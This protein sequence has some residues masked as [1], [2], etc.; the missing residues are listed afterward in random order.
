MDNAIPENPH[1]AVV[2]YLR[3]PAC[4]KIAPARIAPKDERPGQI[5]TPAGWT[6]VCCGNRNP[7]TGREIVLPDHAVRC[8][9]IWCQNDFIAPATARLYRCPACG[10]WQYGPDTTA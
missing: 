3:C 2:A 4:G 1:S 9:R 7:Y 5:T 10:N 8:I 6:C